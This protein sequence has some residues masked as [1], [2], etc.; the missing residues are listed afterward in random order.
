LRN[1]YREKADHEQAAGVLAAYAFCA[2]ASL[3]TA[4]VA[5]GVV[6]FGPLPQA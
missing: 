4:D 5:N 1:I 6:D 3:K 2:R